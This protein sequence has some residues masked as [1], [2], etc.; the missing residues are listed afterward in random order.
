MVSLVSGRTALLSLPRLLEHLD[1]IWPSKIVLFLLVAL[2]LPPKKKRKKRKEESK[3]R[4]TPPKKKRKEKQIP[5]QVG[6]GRQRAGRFGI[7]GCFD[8]F[9]WVSHLRAG[10]GARGNLFRYMRKFKKAQALV[11][12]SSHKLKVVLEEPFHDLAL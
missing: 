8:M 6:A 4:V 12:Y 2:H 9:G 10:L 1:M 11:G 7:D 3:K 5:A